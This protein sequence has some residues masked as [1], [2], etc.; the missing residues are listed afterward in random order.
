MEELEKE[1]GV[2]LCV[3]GAWLTITR[4]VCVFPVLGLSSTRFVLVSGARG[5]RR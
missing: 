3:S 2:C 1:V 5:F 4:F